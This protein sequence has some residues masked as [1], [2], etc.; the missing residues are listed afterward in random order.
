MQPATVELGMGMCSQMKL[1]AQR[2]LPRSRRSLTEFFHVGHLGLELGRVPL[3]HKG[4]RMD[5]YA[6]RGRPARTACRSTSSVFEG[7]AGVALTRGDEAWVR[8]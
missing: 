3:G 2:R 4:Q 5:C 1:A 7:D 6:P 8:Q